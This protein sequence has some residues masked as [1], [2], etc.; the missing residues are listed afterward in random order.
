MKEVV[1][2]ARAQPAEAQALYDFLSFGCREPGS[3]DQLLADF[4]ELGIPT[5]HLSHKERA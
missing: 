3:I 1:A 4:A 5:A 2:I